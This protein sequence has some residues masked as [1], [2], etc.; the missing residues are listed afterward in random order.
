MKKQIIIDLE[1]INGNVQVTLTGG[2]NDDNE[3]TQIKFSY[4]IEEYDCLYSRNIFESV[5]EDIREILVND[6]FPFFNFY[7]EKEEPI[8]SYG[9]KYTEDAVVNIQPVKMLTYLIKS[10]E[11]YK[12]GKTK[13]LKSRLSVYKTHNIQTELI[14]FIETDCEYYLHNKFKDKHISGEWFSLNEADINS[15]KKEYSALINFN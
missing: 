7:P 15:I 9:F 10:G 1:E 5:G 4:D 11:N 13:N 6:I 8:K 2:P 14:L 12:I 3:A